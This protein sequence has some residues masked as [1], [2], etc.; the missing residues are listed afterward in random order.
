ML[1]ENMDW[2]T[3]APFLKKERGFLCKAEEM[4]TFAR[5]KDL[6]KILL[7][8]LFFIVLSFLALMFAHPI[9]AASPLRLCV[10]ATYDARDDAVDYFTYFYG[11]DY[12]RP[13]ASD[14]HKDGCDVIVRLTQEGNFLSHGKLTASAESAYSG[15]KLAHIEEDSFLGDHRAQAAR[16]LKKAL[17]RGTDAYAQVDT[18]RRQTGFSMPVDA[19]REGEPAPEDRTSGLKLKSVKAK[20][21][22]KKERAIKVRSKESSIK[23]DVDELPLIKVKPNKN[24]Y[25]IVIGIEQYRQKLPKAD[26]AVNDAKLVGEYLSRVMGYPEE[27]IVTITNEHATKSDFEKYFEQW[28]V[29]HI[30]KDSTLFIYYSGHGAPNPKTGDAYLVPYDG[31]PAFIAQTGYP[32]KKLY[33][34]LGKL[35]AKEIVVALDSCF[36]GG[37]GRSVIA[38][39]MRPLVID[40][41]GSA[42]ISRN[43]AV[44]SA[45]SGE[46]TSSTYDEKGHG[47]FTYFLLK[48]IKSGNVLKPDGS[49][50]VKNLYDYL[51]PQVERIARRQFNNEQTPQL[52]VPKKN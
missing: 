31:D 11:E 23:S 28:L 6:R 32:L 12:A 43:M 39:G 9:L 22:A 13:I 46:Q 1:E 30:E 52:I 17:A 15:T 5:G 21:N 51:K 19:N 18:E 10:L 45:S 2:L 8:T 14:K 36:S 29:N 44:L 49:I 27:N 37:G 25:A 38:R 4:K 42:S 26:Y 41:Q 3:N 33:G 16:D 48:G 50:R 20:S 24:A 34:V 47:L 35:P 7:S 40:L